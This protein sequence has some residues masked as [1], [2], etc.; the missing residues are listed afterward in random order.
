MKAPKVRSLKL[1]LPLQAHLQTILG[2]NMAAQMAR[3]GTHSEGFYSPCEI[4]PEKV[5]T[6]SRILREVIKNAVFQHVALRALLPATDMSLQRCLC[7]TVEPRSEAY[8]H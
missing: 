2:E 1:L 7:Q 4:F 5:V 6:K 3:V 8:V